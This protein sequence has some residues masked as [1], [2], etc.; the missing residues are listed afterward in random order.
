[1]CVRSAKIIHVLLVA[2]LCYS[3]LVA[4]VHVV[5]HLQSGATHAAHGPVH[6]G[7]S[8]K[9]IDCDPSG[10]VNAAILQLPDSDGWQPPLSTDHHLDRDHSDT[11]YDCAIYHALLSLNGVSAVLQETSGFSPVGRI[12]TDLQTEGINRFWLHQRRNRGPPGLS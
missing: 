11:G 4:S 1:M 6:S 5:G 2:V 10:P 9:N 3:Q 8:H 12:K 7:D